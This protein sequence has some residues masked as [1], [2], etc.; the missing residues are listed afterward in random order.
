M[1]SIV[2]DKSLSSISASMF[3]VDDKQIN[4]QIYLIKE[5][6]QSIKR[7]NGTNLIL[8]MMMMIN[9]QIVSYQKMKFNLIKEIRQVKNHILLL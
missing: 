6:I 5:I 8:L 4:S 9:H 1:I 2:N 7:K 3:S